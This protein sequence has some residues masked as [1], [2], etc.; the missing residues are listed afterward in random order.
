MYEHKTKGRSPKD[1]SD[2]Q[3]LIELFINLR[4][5]SVSPRKMKLKN[6]NE[7]D[8]KPDVEEIKKGNKCISVCQISASQNGQLFLWFKRKNY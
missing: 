2:Y 6:E 3:H 1:C 7:I 4:D 5:G 8:L